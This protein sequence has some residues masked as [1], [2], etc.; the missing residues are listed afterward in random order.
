MKN[1]TVVDDCS[2]F[3]GFEL[4]RTQSTD[5]TDFD[6]FIGL[7]QDKEIQATVE[8]T[9]RSSQDIKFLDWMFWDM[10]SQTI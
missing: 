7:N 2:D 9:E 5:M 1:T 3:S 8:V 6:L 4:Q 10:G